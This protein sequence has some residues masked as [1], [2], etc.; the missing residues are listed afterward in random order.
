MC[1]RP[2]STAPASPASRRTPAPIEDQFTR[3][4]FHAD[5]TVYAQRRRRAPGQV[6]RAVRPHRQ[7]GAERRTASARHAPLGAG[8]GTDVRTTRSCSGPY[9]YYSVRSQTVDPIHGFIT[10]GRHPHEQL[11]F[12]VQDAWTLNNKLTVNVGVRTERERVPTYYDW[13]RHPG[14]RRRVRLQGQVRSARRRRLRRARR[15]QVEDLRLVGPV[16]RLL[17]AGASARLVRRRQV[18]RV[19][20]HARHLR[21]AEPARRLGLPAGLPGHVHRPDRLPPSVVRSGRA[22]I[23]I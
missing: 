10:A 11:G 14:V 21:L 8:S 19:L 23:R 2:C 1:R 17:Q 6:R 9:G 3:A 22:S 15:R 5:G 18:D 12:F 13:R 20:L 7:Q 4:F 16:L